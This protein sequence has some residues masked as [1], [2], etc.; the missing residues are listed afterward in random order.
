MCLYLQ[1]TTARDLATLHY[2]RARASYRLGRHC[3]AIDDCCAALD[4]DYTYRNAIAQRAEC[5]MVGDLGL[6]THVY[7]VPSSFV[8]GSHWVHAACARV[9]GA[10]L[11]FVSVPMCV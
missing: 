1:T 4:K 3:A 2:N 6:V 8:R 9:P 5:Y 10:L 7:C 11:A